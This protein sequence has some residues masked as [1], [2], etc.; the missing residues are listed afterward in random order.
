MRSADDLNEALQSRSADDGAQKRNAEE[1]SRGGMQ[2]S[3]AE[4][5][6]QRAS[7]RARG[8]TRGMRRRGHQGTP[9]ISFEAGTPRSRNWRRPL[10]V[11]SSGEFALATHLP[12]IC[13]LPL[14]YQSLPSSRPSTAKFE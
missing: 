8:G 11:S 3:G 7:S 1:W 5:E 14:S 12:Q 9:R 13:D 10:S 6:V 2:T 4:E